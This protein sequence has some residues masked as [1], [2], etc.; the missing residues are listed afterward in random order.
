MSIYHL[1]CKIGSRSTGANAV[2]KS[3]YDSAGL[4]VCAETGQQFDYRRKSGV[5][6]TEILAPDHAPDWARDRQ[7]LWDAV[8]SVESRKNSQLY[9]E[10]EIALPCELSAADRKDLA[11]KFAAHLVEHGMVVDLAIHDPGPLSSKKNTHAH[12]LCTT[13]KFEENG[14]WSRK[15]ARE[16]NDY[17]EKPVFLLSLRETWATMCND[18]LAKA[19][20]DER[21]SHKSLVA[22]KEDALAAGDTELAQV[23]DRLPE[24]HLGPSAH[25]MEVKAQR[26]AKEEGVEYQPVTRLGEMRHQAVKQRSWLQSAWQGLQAAKEAVLTAA[27]AVAAL[28]LP[29][30]PAKALLTGS[31][32]AERLNIFSPFDFKKTF[33]P[34]PLDQAKEE[35]PLKKEE[36]PWEVEADYGT[37]D[38]DEDSDPDTDLDRGIE[39]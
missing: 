7:K 8:H 4:L 30:P 39:P 33:E 12:L 37:V 13:R 6:H 38:W 15:K 3:A 21:V 35:D 22:Q 24:P 36:A 16:W 2:A 10:Y 29:V 27:A 9:R 14:D 26:R 23:F 17:G 34:D 32:A 19:G 20:I 31:G 28:V 18:A 25:A 1:T 11:Q 5:I